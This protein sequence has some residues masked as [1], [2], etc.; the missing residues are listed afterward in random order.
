M[1]QFLPLLLR[2]PSA[3]GTLTLSFFS[4]PVPST[5]ICKSPF[6]IPTLFK[7]FL[8]PCPREMPQSKNIVCF[9]FL[10]S[11]TYY[12]S[13]LLRRK[14]KS[15]KILKSLIPLNWIS[16]L[17]SKRWPFVLSF[18][19]YLFPWIIITDNYILFWFIESKVPNRYS[20]NIYWTN[21]S[22]GQINHEKKMFLGKE[23][24]N[25]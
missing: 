6:R 3:M 8:A 11:R 23:K 2:E 18:P 17:L 13:C 9:D 4:S 15:Q 20:I 10:S 22:S 19:I 1:Q 24:K 7:L 25:E 14:K 21:E 16:R 12:G 5:S